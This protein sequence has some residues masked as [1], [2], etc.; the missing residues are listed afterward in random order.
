MAPYREK[1]RA[2]KPGRTL[3]R[4]ARRLALGL[5][6][7]QRL[8]WTREGVCYII[9]WLG[10]LAT[11][12]YQQI[13]L[14]LLVAGLAAGPI[15][16]SIFA[17]AAMLRRLRIARRV[18]PYVFS[19]APLSIDYT[20]ENDR[21]W[22]AAL[23]LV[24]EDD[25]VPIDRSV[26]GTG[27]LVPTVFFAR[28]PAHER[29]WVRWQGPSPK[30][31]KYWFRT[32]DLITRSP[33]GLLERRVTISESGSLIVYPRVGQLS[34][35]WHLIQ[36][37]ANETR[38]GLRH[39]RS[40]QQQEYHG[41]RDYR[42]GDS[43]R[44][45]H[46]RTSARIGKPM[47]KEFEQQHEQD[48]AI[49]LD[50]WLPRTKVTAEQREALEQAIQF[51]ATVCLETCRQQGRR[52]LLGWTGPTPGVRQGPS[53]V[54]LVHELLEQLAVM[55]STAEGTLAALFDAV[56]PS[57]LREAILMV[58]STRPVNLIEEAE[59]SAR[60]SGGAARG[61]M[62]RVILFD[63]SRGD[64]NDLVQFADQASTPDLGHRAAA[65]PSRDELPTDG[66]APWSR[67]SDL[68]SARDGAPPDQGPEPVSRDGG[69]TRS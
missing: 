5:L 45:I 51:A 32:M 69:E 7:T 17:S 9:V 47:V 10:L 57:T 67:P 63:A 61:L 14:I 65:A 16:G 11:G 53:S 56:P 27:S 6:P 50:P 15:V 35:R 21:R 52:L 38:R 8:L 60:L 33:F 2:T 1:P 59:R 58:V 3:R 20:L 41:L 54:K 37:Q 19:G 31:G 4:L 30:R 55:R 66:S 64:L 42:P 23:A 29:A 36:R 49:L 62:G 68:E 28:V 22:T 39:D 24:I 43:P 18:P 46:W 34:R 25:L 48:L 12:L 13:N 44:W 40:A 26:S